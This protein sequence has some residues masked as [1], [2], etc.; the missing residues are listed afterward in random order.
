MQ[1]VDALLQ[2]DKTPLELLQ[3]VVAD[4]QVE[5]NCDVKLEIFDGKEQI[6]ALLRSAQLEEGYT[7]VESA[8]FL[9]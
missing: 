7:F 8:H 9:L 6:Q 2:V 5:L 4:G 3:D 1:I